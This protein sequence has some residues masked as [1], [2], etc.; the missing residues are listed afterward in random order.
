MS[1]VFKTPKSTLNTTTKAIQNLGGDC[2][3]CPEPVLES[4]ELEYTQNGE[5]TVTPE[6][7]VD[8]FSSIDVTVN[9]P[10]DV[11]NQNKTVNPS[12]SSQSVSADSGYSGLGTVTVNPVTAAIDPH[13]Q[14]ENIL[15]GVTILGVSGTDAGYDVGYG[16]GE[17]DGYSAGYSEG[18]AQGQSECPEP[19]EPPVLNPLSVT[20]TTSA[21]TIYPDSSIEDGFSDVSVAAVTAAIDQNITAGNIKSGVTILGVSGSYNPQPTLTNLNITPSTNSQEYNPAISGVDGYSLVRVNAVT[22]AIDQNITAGNIKN[23]VSILGVTGNYNPQPNLTSLTVTAPSIGDYNYQTPQGYDGIRAI[24]VIVP[25]SV[26]GT[27]ENP[28]NEPEY[29]PTIGSYGNT[30]IGFVICEDDNVRISQLNDEPVII[31]E[32]DANDEI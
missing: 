23:G 21:Q 4:K 10:S 29:I 1:L 14:A 3:P 28:I 9:I 5:Y 16:Q 8:G 26:M 7:G 12:T 17:S 30:Y 19:P 20:P 32:K 11:N 24:N 6:E 31:V 13:I 15:E 27:S 22:S 18:Y 25:D 2:P